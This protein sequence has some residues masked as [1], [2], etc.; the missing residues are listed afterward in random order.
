MPM[1]WSFKRLWGIE[2][3]RLV[4]LLLALLVTSCASMRGG[5][6][7]YAAYNSYASEIERKNYQVVIDRYLSNRNKQDVM[8]QTTNSDFESEFPIL[9][10]FSSTL[11]K[12]VGHYQK[13]TGDKGCLTINGFDSNSEPTSLNLK[14]VREGGGWKLDYVQIAYHKSEREFKPLATCPPAP[15][16]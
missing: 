10:S 6:D 2:M 8:T 9:S 11:I 4:F 16:F 7:L 5:A 3:T 1:R 15:Q 14:Y 12:E 13:V